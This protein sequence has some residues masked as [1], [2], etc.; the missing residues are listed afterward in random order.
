[1]YRSYLSFL[2]P[3]DVNIGYTEVLPVWSV[4][5]VP[6]ILLSDK[7]RNIYQM[8]VSSVVYCLVY[9][10]AYILIILYFDQY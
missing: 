4:L 1:M 7:T 9:K 2:N 10:N 6:L 5:P 3:A 8:F